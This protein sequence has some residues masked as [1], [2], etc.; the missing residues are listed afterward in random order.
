VPYLIPLVWCDNAMSPHPGP[1]SLVEIA[2]ELTTGAGELIL[3][4]RGTHLDISTKSTPTDIVTV[5]DREVEEWLFA[6]IAARRPDDAIFGEE[7]EPSA[8]SSGIRWLIDPIDGTV[9]FVLGLP[10]FTVSVAAE[11]D[12]QVVAGCVYNPETGELYRATI[13]GGAYLGSRR[14]DGPRDVPLNRAVIGTGFSYDAERRAK[15]GA[16]AA[17]MLPRIADIRRIGSAS[18]DLGFLAAGRLDGFFE[19]GLNPWDWAAGALIATEAG[20]VI[21]GLRGRPVGR[22]AIAV[23]GASLAADFFGLLEELG[24]D[25]V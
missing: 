18:L 23:A 22:P 11:V 9:N 5:V 10:A 25:R 15:Q 17:A 6:Q 13:G 4:R 8:G 7:G 3:A 2:V 20:C 14:L 16:V 21:S 1:E 19:T 24:A 12:G